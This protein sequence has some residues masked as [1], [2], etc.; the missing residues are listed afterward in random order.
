[1]T[2]NYDHGENHGERHDQAASALCDKL[3]WGVTSPSREFI[4]GGTDVGYVY[5]FACDDKVT[6]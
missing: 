6:L 3:G 2:I 1:V 5:V 4:R